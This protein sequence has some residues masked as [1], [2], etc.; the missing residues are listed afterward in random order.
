MSNNLGEL[1]RLA[2]WAQSVGLS[3]SSDSDSLSAD[4]AVIGD[5]QAVDD[6]DRV[7]AAAIMAMH[8]GIQAPEVTSDFVDEQ[9]R[10]DHDAWMDQ[11]TAIRDFVNAQA[12]ANADPDPG[13]GTEASDER[14]IADPLAALLTRATPALLRFAEQIRTNCEA[15]QPTLLQ[16]PVVASAA[17]LASRGGAGV[18]VWCRPLQAGVSAVEQLCWSELGIEPILPLRTGFYGSELIPS[19]MGVIWVALS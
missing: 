10:L 2:T 4:V 13:Q 11:C 6:A 1:R 17:L 12:P 19:A 7:A 15:S 18:A 16:G 5:A 14:L 3:A 8:L 9:G